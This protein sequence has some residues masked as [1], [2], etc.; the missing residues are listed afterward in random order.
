MKIVD[1]VGLF[2]M[3]LGTGVYLTI[4]KS[5][6]GE[7]GIVINTMLVSI[8]ICASFVAILTLGKKNQTDSKENNATN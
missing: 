4:M 7:A 5:M 2:A 6:W 1:K 3:G 8:V